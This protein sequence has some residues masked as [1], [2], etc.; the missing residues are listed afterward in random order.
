[1]PNIRWKGFVPRS[2]S[3]AQLPQVLAGPASRRV[4]ELLAQDDAILK[5][6]S[7]GVLVADLT[8]RFL[9]INPAGLAMYGYNS[10][11]KA[12]RTHEAL[13]EDFEALHTD[14][15]PLAPDEFPLRRVLAGE[16]VSRLEMIWRRRG[17]DAWRVLSFNGSLAFDA[18]SSPLLA[19]LTVRDVTERY[20]HE[21]Q[22]RRARDELQMLLDVSASLV[23]TLDTSR[24]LRLLVGKFR[25]VTGATAVSVFRLI[26]QELRVIEYEGPAPREEALAVSIPARNAFAFTQVVQTAAPFYVEDL[27]ADT[28]FGREWRANA[29]PIQKRL[30]AGFRS[31]LSLPLAVQGRT[32]GVIR[33]AHQ[34]PHY[35]PDETIRLATGIANQAAVALEN[36]ALLEAARDAAV[37]EERERLARELHDSVSQILFGVDMAAFSALGNMDSHPERARE[38]L[39]LVYNL[40]RTAQ[41]EMRALIFELRTDTIAT[42]GLSSSLEFA[43]DAL[44]ERY[45]LQLTTEFCTEPD[46]RVEVKETFYRVAIEAVNNVG[47][48]AATGP[49]R[50]RLWSDDVTLGLEVVDSGPGF[51]PDREYPGHFGLK[52]MQERAARAGALLIIESATGG[53]SCVRLLYRL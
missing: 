46:V 50:F 34:Q 8:G 47:K 25:E 40:N 16:Q 1:M 11:E 37:W 28:P 49:V 44:K 32:I 36:A 42:N 26:G 24:L 6:L 41:K 29:L 10:L 12:Q 31:W 19:V 5:T 30:T 33:L 20:K 23:S 17:S 22:L 27:E 39:T 13:L 9:Y 51:D 7:D 14:G 2:G 52:L 35:F 18:Q 4:S 3:R 21:R 15:R 45:G 38:R 53:G 48:H 43:V